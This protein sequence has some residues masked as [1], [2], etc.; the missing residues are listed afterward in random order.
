VFHCENGLCHNL[1]KLFINEN[2]PILSELLS[3]EGVT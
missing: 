2:D 3:P 1:V